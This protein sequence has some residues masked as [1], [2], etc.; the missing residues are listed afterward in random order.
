MKF[1][2]LSILCLFTL[3]GIAQKESPKLVSSVEG[4]KEYSLSNGLQVL[5]IQDPSQ[6]NLVVNI[7]Y[8]VGSRHE[9]YGEKGMAHLLEHML[10]KS[11]TNLGDIKKMLSEKAG[12]ANGT[13]W[14][15]RTNYYEIFPA[16]DDNLRWS[17]EMEA[18]RMLNATILQSDLDQEFSVVRNEFE[19]G[20]NRPS[21]VL[22]QRLLSTAYVWHNYG[23]TTIG[24][25]EDIERVTAETLRVFYEKYYQPDNATLVI[26]GNFDEEKALEY[27]RDY[28]SVLPKPERVL[29][30][31]Y[32]V[33]PPQDGERFVELRRAG[34]SQNVAAVYHT[35]SYAD[36]D[37]PAIDLLLEILK[38]D[39]SGYLYKAL[40]ETQKASSIWAFHPTLRDAGFAYF[41]IE[42]PKDKSLEDAKNT[43][44]SELDKIQDINYTEED[45]NRGKAKLLKQIEDTKNNTIRYAISFTEIIGAGDYRLW[46]VYRDRLEKL[47][48]QDINRVAKKY[49]KPN[50]RTYG[51]F[52]PSES[53]ERVRPKEITDQDIV[54]LTKDY[55]GKED[56]GEVIASFDATITN[57]KNNLTEKSLNSGL[58]YGFL[59]KPIR[60]KRVM[61]SFRVPVGTLEALSGKTHIANL[62]ASMLKSGTTSRTKEQIQDFLDIK[63]SNVNFSWNSQALFIN[64]TTYEEHFSEVM[65]LIKEVLTTS[66]FPENELTKAKLD[67]KTWLESQLNEP[68]AI[69][70]NEMSRHMQDYDKSHIF[71]SFSNQERI[72]GEATVTR[73]QILDFY[74]T[75]LGGNNAVGAVTGNLEQGELDNV[76]KN[77]FER[78]VSNA[79]YERVYPKYFE[80]K[81]FQKKINTPDKENA[82]VAGGLNIKINESHPDYP[83]LLMSNEMLGSGGFL[84]ARIPHRLRELEGIS[85]GAGSFL[86][87]PIDNESGSWG[88]YAFYNPGVVDKVENALK[89]EITKARTSGFTEEEFKNSTTSWLNSRK[90]LLGNDNYVLSLINTSLF[91]NTEIEKFDKLEKEVLELK[92]DEVNEVFKKHIN[93]DNL[94]L[95]FAG[96]FEKK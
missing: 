92:V 29:N 88:A 32:T 91:F 84:T 40:V 30:K 43:F 21:N 38:S 25:K 48:L 8:N 14:Y 83:A 28:F 73:Q 93:P 56:S 55:K 17:I 89:E 65:A 78:W 86:S 53:E 24:S 81:S 75:F 60:G 5:L 67:N 87:V 42:V 72:D 96:D 4:I 80:I 10:F 34:D 71:Y 2:L 62:M 37:Y 77:T 36:E 39:P 90:T 27:I 79:P 9:G 58:K 26:A 41:N 61:A 6:S 46:F 7:V 11:T 52:I 70:F 51:V 85:Y 12:N 63:Q 59:K 49:F 66:V 69:V 22:M 50:N 45:F 13:T 54:A 47:T 16:T 31:T 94:V 64:V 57:I 95:I 76:M 33:E 19:I 82:A 20:E 23:N 1:I 15:D 18:D 35:A 44:L 68:Q 3:T 74:N